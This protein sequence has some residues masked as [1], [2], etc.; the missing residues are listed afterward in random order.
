[1]GTDC[2]F[3]KK[4]IGLFKP[5]ANK[6]QIIH[7]GYTLPD[8]MSDKDSL[9]QECLNEIKK[10]QIQGKDLNKQFS[11]VGQIVLCLIPFF[12]YILQS[13]AFIRIN[14]FRKFLVYFLIIH[15]PSVVMLFY[16]IYIPNFEILFYIGIAGLIG[17]YFIPVIWVID[18]TRE[19]NKKVV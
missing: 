11:V 5:R 8:D 18:W 16:G 12:H 3:C 17:G 10:T 4:K 9:C 13:Y 14:K 2:F 19:Y 15:I 6:K 7:A 1:M